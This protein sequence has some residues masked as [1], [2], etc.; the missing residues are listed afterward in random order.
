MTAR[1]AR[2]NL[3]KQSNKF[4]DRKQKFFEIDHSVLTRNIVNDRIY[5]HRTDSG[6]FDTSYTPAF[7]AD[8]VSNSRLK[9]LGYESPYSRMSNGVVSPNYGERLKYGSDGY[10]SNTSLRNVSGSLLEN[11]YLGNTKDTELLKLTARYL[12]SQQRWVNNYGEYVT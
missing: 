5:Y 1:Y 9:R 8:L 2:F 10:A 12:T 6:S 7:G 4:G 3:A 11:T